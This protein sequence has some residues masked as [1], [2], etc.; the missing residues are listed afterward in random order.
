MASNA[1]PKAGLQFTIGLRSLRKPCIVHGA[2]KLTCRSSPRL[3]RAR[4]GLFL[5]MPFG[6]PTLG[7]ASDDSTKRDRPM[8]GLLL[9]SII[10]AASP[11]ALKAQSAPAA[12]GPL[13]LASAFADWTTW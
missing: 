8:K 12:A 13:F 5:P 3:G 4:F 1:T 10:M 6:H 11:L 7:M 2:P 9:G